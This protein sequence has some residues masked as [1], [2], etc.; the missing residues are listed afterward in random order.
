MEH[1]KSFCMMICVVSLLSVLI[2]AVAPNRMKRQVEMAVNLFLLL[3]L[4][5]PLTRISL[6]DWQALQVENSAQASQLDTDALLGR[7]IERRLEQA[8]S[9]KLEQSGIF[10]EEIR[11]DITVAGDQVEIDSAAVALR[12]GD[13]EQSGRARTIAEELLGTTVLVTGGR[14]VQ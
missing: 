9:E 3:C 10:P 14:E 13:E 5:T 8:L 11:I 7:E 12:T 6:P 1:L 4:L 2:R